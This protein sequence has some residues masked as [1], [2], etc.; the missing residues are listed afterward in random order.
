MADGSRLKGYSRDFY[1]G[2]RQFHFQEVDRQGRVVA[3]RRIDLADVHAIF[4]VRDFAFDR[5]RRFT[6]DDAPRNALAPTK[7]GSLRL[8]VRCVWGEEI[9]GLTWAFE[10]ARA[11]FFLFP[12]GPEERAYNLERAFFT[13]QAVAGVEPAA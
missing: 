7:T 5:Q 1:P 2:K 6:A 9:E 8:K 11:A 12:T 4:F 3:R 10:P 13:A